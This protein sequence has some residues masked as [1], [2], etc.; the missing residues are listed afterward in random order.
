MGGDGRQDRRDALGIV[1][2]ERAAGGQPTPEDTAK[3]QR[4]REIAQVISNLPPELVWESQTLAVEFAEFEAREQA[5]AAGY[6]GPAYGSQQASLDAI[7][8]FLTYW[9]AR[10]GMD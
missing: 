6:L 1:P 3:A 5:R 8:C 10:L 4:D 2:P 7:K 9:Q